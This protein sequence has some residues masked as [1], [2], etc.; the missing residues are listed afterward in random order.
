MSTESDFFEQVNQLL[1]VTPDPIIEYRLHYNECGDIVMCTMQEHPAS[2]NYVVTDKNTYDLYFRYR[3]V[4]KRLELIKHD[5]GLK[6]SLVK[7][8]SGFR[9]ASNHAALLLEPD[10]TYNNIEYYDSRN[11]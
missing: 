5:D 4:N 3:V 6:S 1:V 8:T 11:S 10:E 9:V 2:D 7:S